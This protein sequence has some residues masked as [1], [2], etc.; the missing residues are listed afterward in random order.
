METERKEKRERGGGGEERKE[1]RGE[2]REQGGEGKE[3]KRGN[4]RCLMRKWRHYLP[5]AKKI[6]AFHAVAL[7]DPPTLPTF[8]L[9]LR[10]QSC[11]AIGKRASRG[12]RREAKQRPRVGHCM[13][14]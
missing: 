11:I 7:P 13:L 2:R 5:K 6:A 4:D 14:E 9:L 1:A 8:R 12:K 3:E 10:L